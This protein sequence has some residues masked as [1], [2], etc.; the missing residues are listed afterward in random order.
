MSAIIEREAT[1]PHADTSHW[2]KDAGP[3]EPNPPL[4]GELT[5][6]VAIIGG[7]FTGLSTAYHLLEEQPSLR[8]VVLEGEVVA[9]GASGR[10][11][12]FSMTLFGLEPLV[13]KM[14]FGRERTVEAHRYM[15][16]AVDHV[17]SLVEKHRIRSDYEHTGFLR[18]ATT[19]AYVERIQRD[20]EVL[21]GMGVRGI[22]WWDEA[23]ARA[24]VDS[25]LVLGAWRERRCGLLHPAKHVRELARIAEEAGAL[26]FERT[27]VTRVTRGE[28][29]RLETPRG[30]VTAD[31]VVF[32]TNAWSFQFPELR[33]KQVA[34]FTHIV[35]TERLSS[36]QLD[37]IGWAGREG[38]EDARNLVHYFRLTPDDRVLMGGSDVTLPFG[39]SMAH[40]RNAR[41]FAGLERD[42]VTVFPQ[43]RGVKIADRWGGPVSVPLDMVPAIGTVGDERAIYSLGC[44]GHG[45]SLTQLNGKTIAH[46]LLG[47]RSDLTDVWFVKRRTL[48]WPPEPLRFV[49]G[50]AIKAAL[51]AQDWW[52]ERGTKARLQRV[53]SL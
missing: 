12:G 16:R 46:L 23:R 9:F 21:E 44:M 30:A 13:T 5:C 50:H 7:G 10:N 41:T 18:L 33:R 20:L 22:E 28:R 43:L 37:A 14:L 51:K 48:P 45:V 47:K 26:V 42:L 52:C 29:F 38:L 25:P 1:I 17:R 27:P 36:K 4:V 3:Y 40:D 34:A 32:A 11:A 19:P 53:V 31:R 15:E 2:I 24:A 35:V 39:R 6:D 8:V 49:A